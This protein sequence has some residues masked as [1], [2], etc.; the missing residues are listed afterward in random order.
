MPAD[1]IAYLTV[2]GMALVTLLSRTGGFV[3]LSGMT[4]TPALDAFL[5]A[6]ASSVVVAVMAPAAWHGDWAARTAIVVAAVLMLFTRQ[7]WLAMLAGM[8]SAALVRAVF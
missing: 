4:V 3:L 2:A 1:L 7:A 8:A 5:R 6:L